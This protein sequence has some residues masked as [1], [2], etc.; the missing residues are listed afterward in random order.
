MVSFGA[1]WLTL[2]HEIDDADVVFFNFPGNGCTTLPCF[3]AQQ[4]PAN[5]EAWRNGPRTLGAWNGKDD[6]IEV[7]R[8]PT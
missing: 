4:R 2:L 7:A 3:L 5:L 6:H 8:Q 1:C